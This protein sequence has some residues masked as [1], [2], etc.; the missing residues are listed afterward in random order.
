VTTG[1]E[2]YGRFYWCIGVAEAICKAGQ[3]YVHADRIELE[4]GALLCVRD[5]TDDKDRLVSLAFAPGEWRYFFGASVFDG[6]AVSVEHWDGEIDR[7][8]R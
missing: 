8:K 6:H 3:V 2:A 1:C 5:A 7:G 4:N